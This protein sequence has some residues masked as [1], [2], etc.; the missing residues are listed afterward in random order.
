VNS[1]RLFVGNLDYS[2]VKE[3]L[4]D[5]FAPFGSVA[6]INVAIDRETGKPRGF[7][8]VEYS[9]AADAQS[10]MAAV[11]GRDLR[12]RTLRVSEARERTDSASQSRQGT[13]GSR[14]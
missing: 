13:R 4:V 3:E 6:S 1:S 2:A 12:G 5:I 9:N 14:G 7:A 10:A 8:F 11:D